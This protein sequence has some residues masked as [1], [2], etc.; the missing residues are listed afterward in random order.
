MLKKSILPLLFSLS[1]LFTGCNNNKTQDSDKQTKKANSMITSNEYVL[2]SLD[3]KQLVVSKEADGFKL[4]GAEG[5]VVIFD[6]FATWCPPCRAAASH[7]SSLQKK[8]KDRLVIVGVTIEEN[9]PNTKLQEFKEQYNA[10]YTLVNSAQN[11]TLANSIVDKL[12]LGDRFPIPIM[13]LYKDGKYI[14]HYI[15]AIQEEF[16]E[17]DIKKALGI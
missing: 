11:R 4:E 12:D 8:Y 13:A 17:S 3:N 16:I 7:L 6:I 14:N 15:G 10:N 9:I 1:I 2:T 5:K